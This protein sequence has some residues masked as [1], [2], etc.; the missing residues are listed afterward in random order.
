MAKKSPKKPTKAK[1][2]AKK[3]SPAKHCSG[4]TITYA[5]AAGRSLPKHFSPYR[6]VSPGAPGAC[7]R[8][9]HAVKPLDGSTLSR[10]EL[11]FHHAP[12]RRPA[13]KKPAAKKSPAKAKKSP[14]K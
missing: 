3:K 10:R 6:A 14:K 12:A 1:A 5:C 13:A 8:R 9:P 11:E 7:A 2:A 4:V